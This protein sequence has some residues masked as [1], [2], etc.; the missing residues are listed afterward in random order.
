MLENND[1]LTFFAALGDLAVTGPTF[2]NLN[3]LRVILVLDPASGLALS[4]EGE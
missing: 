1:S 4:R 2:N 3:D